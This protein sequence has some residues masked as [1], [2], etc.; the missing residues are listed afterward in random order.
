MSSVEP[1][2]G[3]AVT[4]AHQANQV[5][6][7][8]RQVAHS[9]EMKVDGLG[10]KVNEVQ[11]T[12]H[13]LVTDVRTLKQTTQTLKQ[14]VQGDS[15][16]GHDGLKKQVEANTEAI[17]TFNDIRDRFKYVLL[18]WGLGIAVAGGTTVVGLLK[19]LGVT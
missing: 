1:S 11:G 2:I 9:I 6:E 13:A 4:I 8:A 5:A 14:T 16:I 19:L 10:V 12:L 17:E 7:A 18:G 3:P 15:E